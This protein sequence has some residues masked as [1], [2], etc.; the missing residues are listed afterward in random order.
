MQEIDNVVKNVKINAL[1]INFKDDSSLKVLIDEKQF[2][3]FCAK[4]LKANKTINYGETD[5][6]DK[7]D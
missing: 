4:L 3:D 7:K 5:E 2:D 6:I 1:A